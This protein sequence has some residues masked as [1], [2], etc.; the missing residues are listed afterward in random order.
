MAIPPPAPEFVAATVPAKTDRV[1]NTT[2]F[3]MAMIHFGDALFWT[4]IARINHLI[5]PWV[6]GRQD[7]LIPPVQPQTPPTGILG[8]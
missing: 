5:D 3:H 8:E 7:I 4:N 1:S 6:F 2:L